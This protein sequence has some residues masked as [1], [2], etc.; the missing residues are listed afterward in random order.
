MCVWGGLTVPSVR[1][2][3]HSLILDSGF[4]AMESALNTGCYCFGA[5]GVS[6]G[7]DESPA[8]LILAGL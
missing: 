3:P 4:G 8:V 5:L 2:R 6:A 7:K 1:S